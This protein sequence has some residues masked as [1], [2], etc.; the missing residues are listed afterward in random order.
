MAEAYG[1]CRPTLSVLTLTAHLL[2][3]SNLTELSR[4]AAEKQQSCIL[5]VSI[6]PEA[7]VKHQD[8]AKEEDD[9]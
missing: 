3:M 2:A 6:F 8:A 1:P 4:V 5:Y 7:H 9:A